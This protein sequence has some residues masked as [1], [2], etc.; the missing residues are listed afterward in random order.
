MLHKSKG[1]KKKIIEKMKRPKATKK[2][3]VSN[4][5]Q[6]HKVFVLGEVVS[7]TR[8]SRSEGGFFP[9][10]PKPYVTSPTSENLFPTR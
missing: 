2:I 4:K 3:V 6:R 8:V 9:W 10:Y 7:E 1:A 5:Y